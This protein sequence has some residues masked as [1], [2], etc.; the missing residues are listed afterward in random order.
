L[1]S[2]SEPNLTIS[3]RDGK[4]IERRDEQQRNAQ[5]QI[6]ISFEPGSNVISLSEV[7]LLKQKLGIRSTS[8]GMQIDVNDEQPSNAKS[9]M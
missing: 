4:T 9:P 8:A 2:A 1:Q 3:T 7:Q 5:L 6:S